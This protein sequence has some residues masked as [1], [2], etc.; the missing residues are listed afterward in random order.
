MATNIRQAL[1]NTVKT[2]SSITSLL[3]NGADSVLLAGN[4]SPSTPN[5]CI[6]IK[7]VGRSG[8]PRRLPFF[9]D[10]YFIYVYDGVRAA[11]A[12]SVINIDNIKGVLRPVVHGASLS[13]D[14]YS[15]RVLEC[16]MEGLDSPDM[17]DEL[18]DKTYSFIR[19]RIEGVY[20]YDYRS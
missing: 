6:G 19:V 7:F 16:Y 2:A 8:G 10:T 13:V 3:P 18:L 5:P 11:Q 14:S 15:E 17:W 9:I 12:V 20:L 1:H 4:V